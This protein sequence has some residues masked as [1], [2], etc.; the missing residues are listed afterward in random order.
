MTSIAVVVL[1]TL[2]KDYFDDYFD[3]LPGL[4]FD[5]AYSTSN[6]T[7]PAHASLFTGKYG[8][9]VNV[10]SKAIALDCDRPVLAETLS[11]AGFKTKGLSANPNASQRQQFDRGFDEFSGPSELKSG[12]FDILDTSKFAAEHDEL[13]RFRKYLL[14]VHEIVTGDYDTFPSLWASYKKIRGSGW[15][16]IPDDGA[17]VVRQRAR[18][19]D[20]GSNEFLFVNLVEAHTPYYPPEAYWEFKDPV[21]MEFGEAYLGVDDPEITRNGY[22]SAV[23]YLSDIYRD[24][25]ESLSAKFDYVITLSD[26][27]ELLGDH[28]GMWNHVSG[29]YPEL[30]HIPLVISGSGLDGTSETVVSILDLYD[31]I[32]ELAD[33]PSL[34]S[35]GRSIIPPATDNTPYLAEYRG[36][37]THS[38]EKSKKYNF[39][40]EQYDRSLFALIEPGYYGYEDYDGWRETGDCDHEAPQ[41]FLHERVA[42]HEMQWTE[43]ESV[44]L[45][46]GAESRLEKLGYI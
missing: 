7:G 36:P 19:M 8:S 11:D 39:N 43:H 22:D 16:P 32:L 6:W 35:D 44:E 15:R 2:R 1:D 14:A 42:E 34:A 3:W 41:E 4:R 21:E 38:L 26:H 45:T 12:S 25:F 24:I 20:V 37:F 5:A 10:S 18:E 29:I 23:R 30:T 17:S 13:S 31:T 40:L 9:A 27:G 28:H 33:S 46:E